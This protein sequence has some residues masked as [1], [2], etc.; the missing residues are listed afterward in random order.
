MIAAV[1]FPADRLPENFDLAAIAFA[2]QKAGLRLYSNGRQHALLPRAA[3]GW[4][5]AS[6]QSSNTRI[7]AIS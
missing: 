3:K 7:E 1:F 6:G 5:L 2:A 4:T